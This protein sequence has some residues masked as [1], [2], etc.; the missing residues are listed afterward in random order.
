M[1]Y[2]PI[3]SKIALINK[4]IQ[5][6]FLK[7]SGKS[8]H[9]DVSELDL[10]TAIIEDLKAFD[11][12]PEEEKISLKPTIKALKEYEYNQSAALKQINSLSES[13]ESLREDQANQVNIGDIIKKLESFDQ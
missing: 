8:M 10:F 1:A 2:I 12:K 6:S 11:E 5:L 3:K 13:L 9:K 7:S 4:Y